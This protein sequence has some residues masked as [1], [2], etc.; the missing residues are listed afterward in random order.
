KRQEAE[1]RDAGKSA[2]LEQVRLL[3]LNAKPEDIA[4]LDKAVDKLI[5][6]FEKG[7]DMDFINPVLEGE[8]DTSAESATDDDASSVDQV[9]RE[10]RKEVQKAKLLADL[11]VQTH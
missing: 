3:A 11:R 9:I 8:S 5:E 2:T 1:R 4:K 6:F 10:F 7:G